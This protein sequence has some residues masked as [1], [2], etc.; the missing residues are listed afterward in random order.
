MVCVLQAASAQGLSVAGNTAV[1]V[2]SGGNVGIGTTDPGHLLDVNASAGTASV[3]IFNLGANLNSRLQFAE[4]SGG[5]GVELLYRSQQNALHIR[6]IS[7][8]T[9]IMTVQRAGNVG[10]GAT[11]P[12]EMFEVQSG[13]I[14]VGNPNSTSTQRDL[15]IIK[16]YDK[17][18]SPSSWQFA[19]SIELR[20][21]DVSE[22][23]G[24]SNGTA[25]DIILSTGT[26]TA[27]GGNGRAGNIQLLDGN[28]G[29]GTTNPGGALEVN[30][31]VKS[32]Q[33]FGHF[34]TDTSQL[35]I[36]S[37]G[38]GSPDTLTT[39]Y[40]YVS[41]KNIT[42]I[43]LSMVGSYAGT[44]DSYYRLRVA[45]GTST[46]G[47]GYDTGS[48]YTTAYQTQPAGNPWANS[49]TFDI[50]P[51]SMTSGRL[52]RVVVEGYKDA[53]VTT[54]RSNQLVMGLEHN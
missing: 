53:G 14:Q 32:A 17:I 46:V 22:T 43:R 52:F 2:L 19:G 27:T 33:E 54:M 37:T 26:R 39:G 7:T 40:V 24:V 29:I 25:G 41:N 49:F 35:T 8:Q 15:T 36:S 12:E 18:S 48:E 34:F 45:N 44:G 10:I 1:T 38:S 20:A 31:G 47:G 11:N 13:N 3:R 23:G 6:D 5:S 50:S 4:G 9:P 42:S 28:V 21:G 16:A 51:G 30:G